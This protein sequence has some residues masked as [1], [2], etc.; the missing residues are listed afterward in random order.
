MFVGFSRTQFNVVPWTGVVGQTNDA[1]KSIQ[2]VAHGNVNGFTKNSIPLLGV[3][4]DLCVATADVEDDGVDGTRTDSAHFDMTDAMVDANNGHTPQLRECASAQGRGAEWGPHPGAL[5]E[6]NAVDLI[7]CD[8]G[9]G[10]GFAHQGCCV[11]LMVPGC[12]TRQK[13]LPRWGDEGFSRIG[14]DTKGFAFAVQRIVG[15]VLDDANAEFVGRSLQANGDDHVGAF[16]RDGGVER[17]DG[18]AGS[19]HN[20]VCVGNGGEMKWRP[21]G[22]EVEAGEEQVM[23]QK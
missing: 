13:T 20:Y 18:G 22:E 8:T 10:Q 17:D 14:K 19:F 6:T 16:G 23:V 2:T 21:V 4:N 3:R 7:G 5:C 1:R 9:Q 11:C 15:R 12:F